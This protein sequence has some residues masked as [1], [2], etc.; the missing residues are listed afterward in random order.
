MPD[1]DQVEAEAIVITMPVWDTCDWSAR[2]E[3]P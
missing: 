1:V 3:M 2:Q